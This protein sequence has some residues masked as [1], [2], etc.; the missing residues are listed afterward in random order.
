[1]WVGPPISDRF[2]RKWA[3]AILAAS[4]LIVSKW[5]CSR[6][7]WTAHLANYVQAIVFEIVAKEWQVYTAAKMF[8]GK[9]LSWRFVSVHLRSYPF[10]LVHDRHWHRYDAVWSDRVYCRDCVGRLRVIVTSLSLIETVSMFFRPIRI[11]GVLL[12]FYSLCFAIGQLVA[13]IALNVII[14]EVP[15]AYRNAFYSEFVLLGL[16]V[17][18]LVFAPESPCEW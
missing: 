17:P 8:A 11:R 7:E 3:M 5:S 6:S 12:S 2:G 16:M 10:V 9:R 4:L 15:L 14:E 13:S 1:M 18:A